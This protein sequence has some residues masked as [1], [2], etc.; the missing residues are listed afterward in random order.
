MRI[1]FLFLLSFISID[2]FSQ[3][4][5]LKKELGRIY[6]NLDSADNYL[7][8][9]QRKLKSK[10]DSGIYFYFVAEKFNLQGK[11]MEAKRAFSKSIEFIDPSLNPELISLA[12]IRLTRIDQAAGQFDLALNHAQDGIDFSLISAD[13]NNLA[14]HLLDIAVIHHDMEDYSKGVEYGKRAIEILDQYSKANPIYRAFALNSIAINFDDWSKPDSALFYH[15]KI[16]EDM[17]NLDSMRV[18]FTFN[19]IGNTLIKQ[20]RYDEAKKWIEIAL[21]LNQKDGYPAYG[22]ATNYTNLANIAYNLRDYSGARSLMDSAAYY[23]A[24]SGSTEKKRDYLFEEYR[25]HKAK[26]D[27]PKAM[28]FLEQYS[29]LKDTIFQEERLMAM[30]EMEARYEVEQKER[31]LAESRAAL[32]ENE[33]LVEN[34]NNQLLMLLVF[35]LLSLGIGFF[36]YY[37]QK[38]KNRHLRQEAKL[39]AIYAEQE[40]QKRLKTQRDEI[41]S[42]L[43]DNIGSQ[44]TFIVSSLNNLKFVD[45]SKEKMAQKIDQI[46]G[47]TVETVNELRDTIWAM[48]KD[49]MTIE[50]LRGRVSN[51]I[52]K[53]KESCPD[54]DFELIIDENV[55]AGHRLNSLEGVN[56]YRIIQ[57]ALNNS[58]KYAHASKVQIQIIQGM[59]KVRLVVKDNGSGISETNPFGNGLGTM[60]T[61]A[62]RIGRSMKVNTAP[63]KGTEIMID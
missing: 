40:T 54:T 19:N 56:F 6:S 30:S 32:A 22:L 26:G 23:V 52:A 48:N 39:Q 43:H 50:D 42:D 18:I 15:F 10:A 55:D 17:E 16:I 44:L 47:F 37:R 7:K 3:N 46:S 12:Y 34:R 62:S 33:L 11:N 45:L 9:A 20:E 21:K 14:Y 36:I 49:S 5:E 31:A 59:D 2:S 38:T 24:L 51:L 4:K 60:K 29:A 13:S 25:F 61:R 53:A 63:D 28:D 27:L 35:L 41:A 8:E 58:I 1:I 57:E